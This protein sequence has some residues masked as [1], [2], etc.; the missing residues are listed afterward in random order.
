[1]PHTVKVERRNNELVIHEALLN[2]PDARL[3]NG[4]LLHSEGWVNIGH[5]LKMFLVI[6]SENMSYRQGRNREEKRGLFQR[7]FAKKQQPLLEAHR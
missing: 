2:G 3:P 1:M 7:L 5:G 6:G 4:V